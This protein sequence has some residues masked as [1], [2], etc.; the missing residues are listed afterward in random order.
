MNK[1]ML[2]VLKGNMIIIWMGGCN[3][4]YIPKVT[5]AINSDSMLQ[6]GCSFKTAILERS[7]TWNTL[8][9]KDFNTVRGGTSYLLCLLFVLLFTYTTLYRMQVYRI[10]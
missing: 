2:L 5:M 4:L 3:L 10:R 9:V 1:I 6:L 7:C 8:R